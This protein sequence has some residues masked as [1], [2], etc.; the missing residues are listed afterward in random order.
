MHTMDL[1]REHEGLE[2]WLCPACGRRMTIMWQPWKR[3][4][5]EVG[6]VFAGHIASKGGLSVE[7]IQFTRGNE[8]VSSSSGPPE[9]SSD[10]PYLAPWKRWIDKI[11]SDDSWNRDL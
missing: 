8:D 5:L 4:V 6:D 3:T 9:L 1:I 7:P 11:D 2:E 10:D